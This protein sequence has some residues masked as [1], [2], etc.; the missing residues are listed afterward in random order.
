MLVK[1]CGL[2]SQRDAEAA[3]AAGADLLG[4]VFVAGT[5]RAVE[6][7]EASWIRDFSGRTV[8]VF[9]NASLERVLQVRR[10][11]GLDWVQLHGDEP[12]DWLDELGPE[13]LRCVPV[14]GDG[15]DWRRVE[16]LSRQSLPLVDP[17]AGDGQPCDWQ[18]LASGRP[19][20]VRFGLAGGLS[21]DNVEDAVRLLRPELV[22]VSS[23]VEAVPGE[24]DHDRIGAFINAAR[25]AVLEP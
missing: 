17:G 6:P 12:D 25:A 20:T 15:L 24:K 18:V 5:P 11:L 4:F 21:P 10:D 14:V 23:G 19:E 8:G 16:I 13:V 1:I 2:T 3:I 9:R 22:D 7:E